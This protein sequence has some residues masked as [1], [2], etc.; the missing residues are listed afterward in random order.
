MA[1]WLF[2]DEL[3]HLGR[4]RRTA[5]RLARPR[6]EVAPAYEERSRVACCDD[7]DLFQAVDE[8]FM[9]GTLIRQADARGCSRS[10]PCPT[11]AWATTTR[12]P[13]CSPAGSGSAFPSCPPTTSRTAEVTNDDRARTQPPRGTAGRAR[14]GGDLLGCRPPRPHRLGQRGQTSGPRAAH[15][16]RVVPPHRELPRSLR[17]AG[18]RRTGRRRDRAHHPLR[19]QRHRADPGELSARHRCDGQVP[20]RARVREGGARRQLGRRLDRA[21]LPGAGGNPDDH[22]A[23][24]RRAGPHHGRAP[25][26]R[27]HRDVQRAPVAR[28]PVHRVARPSHRRSSNRS[29]ATPRSTCTTRTTVRPI[30]TSS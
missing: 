13:R 14:Q 3:R 26:G 2:F 6:H 17:A 11:R 20:T 23:P 1:H 15:R 7:L 10:R 19:G 28:A 8:L 12:S 30:P 27:R 18:P 21:L 25:A 22:R 9:A 4:R 5:R 29:S 16:G 24:G